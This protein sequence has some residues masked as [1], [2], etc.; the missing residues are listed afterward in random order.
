MQIEIRI[1][2]ETFGELMQKLNAALQELMPPA[3]EQA[4]S[5]AAGAEQKEQVPVVEPDRRRR[6]TPVDKSDP[7]A[8]TDHQAVEQAVCEAEPEP[9]SPP[10][11]AESPAQ[12][13]TAEEVR[14]LALYVAQRH[15]GRTTVV[16]EAIVRVAGV[17]TL[18]EVPA[19]KLSDLYDALQAL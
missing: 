16:V 19:E 7:G 15:S 3:I 17:K 6:K 1:T 12:A 8:K 2:A 11:A 18:A 13:P 5:E 14:K 10:K 9:A 4:A